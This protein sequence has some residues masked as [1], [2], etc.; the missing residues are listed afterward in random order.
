MNN[1]QDQRDQLQDQYTDN[2]ANTEMMAATPAPAPVPVPA[3]AENT[4]PVVQSP[5]L[6]A[7]P[8][9]KRKTLTS[10]KL[11]FACLLT[12]LLTAVICFSFFYI[13]QKKV[14]EPLQTATKPLADQ[15]LGGASQQPVGGRG[16]SLFIHDP[17]PELSPE[18]QQAYAKL[19]DVI[20]LLDNNYYEKPTKLQILENL[21]KGLL[22]NMGSRYTFY[23]SQKDMADQD[24]MRSGAYYGIGATIS[25]Q[26][27][28]YTIVDLVEN[29]PAVRGGLHLNDIIIK[30][31]DQ[32]VDTIPN[33]NALASL[34]RGEKGTK[35]QLTVFRPSDNKEHVLTL[36]RGEIKNHSLHAKI[37]DNHI[38]YV[39]ITEFNGGLANNFI[40]TLNKMQSEG[41]KGLIVDLRNNGGGYVDQDLQMLDYLLPAG[42]IGH[43]EGRMDGK[44]TREEWNSLPSVGFD[45][46][47]PIVILVNNNSAS[48]SE[49]FSGSLKDHK[50]AVLVGQKTFGKGVG[51]ITYQLPDGSGAQITTFRYFLP[52]GECIDGTGI[53]PNYVVELPE[54]E[55]GKIVPMIDP[56]KD[57]Q[58]Q[59][60]IEIIQKGEK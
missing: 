35:V 23:L 7:Q 24:E 56:A 31:N 1:E 41:I 25:K 33:V 47:I 39:R 22:D 58:L 40:N 46:N 30:V 2:T 4:A 55:R 14:I 21:S 51:T 8:P 59:K 11:I 6:G 27:N 17:N 18:E 52:N 20:G 3:P 10:G 34:V 9:L 54:S 50:R 19:Q 37:L 12:A 43:T 49:L 60:A 36:E 13:A 45:Q 26:E 38:G 15:Q 48:A 16:T 57:T 28:G 53:E 32:S 5:E 29:S 44:P 42:E